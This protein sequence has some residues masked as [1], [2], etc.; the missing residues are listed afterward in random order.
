MK[1][2]LTTL[3]LITASIIAVAKPPKLACE[4]IF[5]RDDL[6]IKGVKIV[7]SQMGDT[8]YRSITIEDGKKYYD[9]FLKLVMKDK[10]RAVSVYESFEGKDESIMLTIPNNGFEIMIRLNRKN[11]GSLRLYISGSNEAFK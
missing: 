3:L 7:K 1:R 11:D 5:E 9:E 8:N 2:Q 4:S 6:R 10:P